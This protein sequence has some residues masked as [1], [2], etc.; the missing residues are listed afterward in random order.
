MT[1]QEQEQQQQQEE[2]LGFICGLILTMT[3]YSLD[4]EH[5]VLSSYTVIHISTATIELIQ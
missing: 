3:L 4:T 2:W 1:Q 5:Y